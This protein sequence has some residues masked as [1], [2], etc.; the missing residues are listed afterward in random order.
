M[1]CGLEQPMDWLSIMART[2]LFTTPQNSSLPSNN[3]S[4]IAFDNSGNAWLATYQ[5]IATFNPNGIITNLQDQVKPIAEISI[6][7]NP[8]MHQLKVVSNHEKIK[9]VS[10]IDINGKRIKT[11][12]SAFANNCN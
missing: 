11:V 3:V 10:I 5:G 7:P 9:E 1:T 2:G 12:H 4:S 8:A 6:S